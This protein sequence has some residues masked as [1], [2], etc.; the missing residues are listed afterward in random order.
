MPPLPLL[1]ANALALAGAVVYALIGARY[2]RLARRTPMQAPFALFWL[3]IAAYGLAD[4]AWG[5]AVPLAQPPLASG[6]LVLHLKILAGCAAFFGLV[7]YLAYLY[8][9]RFHLIW[10]LLVLYAGVF[11]VVTYSYVARDPVG[12]EVR[13]WGGG[14]TYANEGGILSK[15]AYALLFAPPL[16]GALAYGALLPRAATRE[17]RLRIIATSAAFAVLFGGMLLGWMTNVVPGW[18]LLEKALAVAA[19]AAAFSTTPRDE[20]AP[21][22]AARDATPAPEG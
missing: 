18:P 3:G 21:R 17:Q 13:A 6:V 10:P 8:T 20:K 9:G 11:V 22:E 16:A 1:A 2:A 14:L 4:G 15:V 5:L 7:Y 19:G 12:Q